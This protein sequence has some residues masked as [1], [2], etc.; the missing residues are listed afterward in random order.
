VSEPDYGG[1]GSPGG[2][3][4][5]GTRA[6]RELL[7]PTKIHDVR[8][9]QDEH[10]EGKSRVGRVGRIGCI[11][12]TVAMNGTRDGTHVYKYSVLVRT[13]DSSKRLQLRTHKTC[14]SRIHT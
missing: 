13:L 1:P 2:V 6:D 4:D 3:Y 10:H 11:D 14:T 5:V 8:Q 9:Q 7:A 12:I